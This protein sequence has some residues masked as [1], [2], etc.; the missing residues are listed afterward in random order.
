MANEL[1]QHINRSFTEALCYLCRIDPTMAGYLIPFTPP[2]ECMPAASLPEGDDWL[3]EVKLDGYRAQISHDSRGVRILSRNAKIL[4]SQFPDIV[5]AAESLPFGCVIDGELCALTDKGIP[6]FQL[7]QNRGSVNAPT[8][9]YAFDLLY[10]DYSPLLKRKLGERRAGLESLIKSTGHLQLSEGLRLPLA[11]VLDLVRKHSLEGVV[12][13]RLSSTYEAGLRT[14]AWQKK[15]ITL[16]QEFVIGG[17]TPGDYGI[18]ALVIGFYRGGKLRYCGRVRNGFVPASRRQ[19]FAELKGLRTDVCPFTNLPE[20]AA[21]RWGDGLTAAK[22]KECVW[23]RPEAVAQIEF[24]EWTESEHL[25]HVTFA[26]MRHDKDA[27]KV[28]RET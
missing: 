16:A 25:R 14:G 9:F 12:A 23:L 3:Y 18:D 8:V 27:R 19:V 24:L 15:R 5:R 6:S 26:G 2:M 13:K 20:K 21:G 10:L 17:Y 1:P 28:V 22:M 7:L 4:T 11:I